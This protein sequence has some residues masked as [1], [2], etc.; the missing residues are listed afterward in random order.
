MLE[1]LKDKLLF[2]RGDANAGVGHRKSDYRAGAVECFTIA[3]PSFRSGRNV[4][5]HTSSLGELE[6]IGEEVADDLFEPLRIGEDLPRQFRIEIHAKIQRLVFGHVAEGPL[7]IGLQ[8]RKAQLGNIKRDGAGLDLGQVEDVV[9]E[10]EQVVARSVNGLGELDLLGQE[11][12]FAVGGELLGQDEQTVQRRAQL[13]R[14]VGHEFRLVFGG[15][16]E[17]C[18]LFFQRLAGLL[19]FGVLAFDFGVLFGQQ[20]GFFLQFLVGVLQFFLA[21]LQFLG[22]RLR[23]LEQIFGASVSFDGIEHDA[24]GFDE[25]VQKGLMNMAEF[26]KGGQFHDRLDLPFKEHRQHDDIRR[27]RLA[28]PGGDLHVVGRSVGHQDAFLFQRRLPDQTLAQGEAVADLLAITE[29]V[30]G[31]ELQIRLVLVLLG[32]FLWR[33]HDVEDAL[34][35]ADHRRQFGE[36]Q[37]ADGE[38]VFLA[39]QHA[40]EL[41][42]I[43]FKPV[44][45]VILDGGILQVADHFVNVVL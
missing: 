17:L 6:G 21:A 38:H 29:G 41:G 24:D 9:D 35:R 19:H 10:G 42:E 11:I 28:Q 27:R 43:G 33:L 12:A 32:F 7:H 8:L 26:F 22:E 20:L 31:Q 36:N 39:L 4:E 16:R 40:C 14:H 23:L 13:V 2:L 15:Q 18:G 44:L 37:L 25:L 30:A 34:L 1:G 3:A 5:H 45:I